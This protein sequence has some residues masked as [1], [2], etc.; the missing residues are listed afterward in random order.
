MNTT[1]IV[2]IVIFSAFLLAVFWFLV[3]Y[4]HNLQ[5]I[6]YLPKNIFLIKKILL[7]FIIC[8]AF[9][10]FFRIITW[11]NIFFGNT[12]FDISRDTRLDF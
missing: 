2:F 11:E 4:F 3:S 8:L 12:S 5:K 1:N 10:G 6:F 7:I 9:F